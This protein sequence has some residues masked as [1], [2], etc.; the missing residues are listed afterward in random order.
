MLFPGNVSPSRDSRDQEAYY[1]DFLEM[2]AE[3][4]RDERFETQND[5]RQLQKCVEENFLTT[6]EVDDVVEEYTKLNARCAVIV[7]ILAAI[8]HGS[9][10]KMAHS[11]RI[12]R[13]TALIERVRDVNVEM[14]EVGRNARRRIAQIVGQPDE[15]RFG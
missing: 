10:H 2:I 5:L 11:V 12:K 14:G 4:M 15:W 13:F 6:V 3:E 7:G 1:L 9:Y 8:H